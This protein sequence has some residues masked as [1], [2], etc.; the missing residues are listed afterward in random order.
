MLAYWN[1]KDETQRL[2][3]LEM[4]LWMKMERITWKD[5]NTNEKIQVLSAVGE[6]RKII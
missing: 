4:W 5:R 2:R 6:R 3:A 1:K